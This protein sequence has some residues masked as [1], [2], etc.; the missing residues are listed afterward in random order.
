MNKDKPISEKVFLFA[1]ARLTYLNLFIISVLSGATY[2]YQYEIASKNQVSFFMASEF[3]KT[4]AIVLI[5]FIT[6]YKYNSSKMF[7][8][9]MLNYAASLWIF[10]RICD[11]TLQFSPSIRESLNTDVNV[12][13]FPVYIV[14]FI[15]FAA[16]GLYNYQTLEKLKVLA[17]CF[18]LTACLAFITSVAIV[19]SNNRHAQSPAFIIA[20]LLDVLI[21]AIAFSLAFYSS[22]DK[23]IMPFTF[24]FCVI[25]IADIFYLNTTSRFDAIDNP[26]VHFLTIIF[27][28]GI[29]TIGQQK[30]TR[31]AEIKKVRGENIML[32]CIET[33]ALSCIVG[34]L[35]YFFIEQKIPLELFLP[36]NAIF[37]ILLASEFLSY[38]HNK[39]LMRSREKSMR[40]VIKSSERF[41]VVFENS[42]T[43]LILL[44]LSGDIVHTNKTFSEFCG[45]E[46]DQVLGYSIGYVIHPDDRSLF[47]I[48]LAKVLGSDTTSSISIEC[49]FLRVDG[50]VRWG[51]TS[52]NHIPSSS[53]SD[54]VNADFVI[55]IE[56][57]TN[58]KIHETELVTMANRD[59][60][61][62]LWNRS[63]LSNLITKVLENSESENDEVGNESEK[64]P[65]VNQTFAVFFLDLDRFKII[66]DT[67]GHAAGD[68]V[69]QTTA[70]RLTHIVGTRGEVARLGGDEFVILFYPPTT[71]AI[72]ELV[73]EE[74]KVSVAQP[75]L[76]SQG[77]TII[78]CSIG[79]LM[80]FGNA[81]SPGDIMREAD[82]AM[83]RAKDNGKNFV[84]IAT[85]KDKNRNYSELKFTNDLRRALTT[86]QIKVYYQ[87]IVSLSTNEIIG[88]EALSRWEHPKKGLIS[89]DEFIPLAE[90]TGL[91]LEIGYYMMEHAFKQLS[92]WQKTYVPSSGKPLSMNVN[93][94]VSQ[95]RDPKLFRQIEEVKRQS[96]CAVNSMIF[97]ITESAVMGDAK[98]AIAL[99]HEIRDLGFRLRIDDFGTGYSS[100]SY[101]KK[102]PIDG[103]KIDKSFVD[104]LD[105]DENDTA[106]VHALLGLAHAMNL[107][108]TAEGIEFDRQRMS[109]K[110]LNCD[111]G[112]GYLFSEAVP[113][114][115]VQLK[116][117]VDNPMDFIRP[118]DSDEYTA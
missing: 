6:R 70:E 15:G 89:P 21:L 2:F 19:I 51:A 84:E 101:L 33:L 107:T 13:Y 9:K 24:S 99:L 27:Y 65:A 47:D 58:K 115:K 71:Q 25:A 8:W 7:G 43:A 20:A 87:P 1:N 78:T 81:L 91:I 3:I 76:L 23:V 62:G 45:L 46:Q 48:N 66:N 75:I 77:E 14:A 44:D 52:I 34:A 100:L 28:L 92:V 54:E 53:F 83:Y 30:E 29:V 68:I 98:H 113:A 39:A 22:F 117:N 26:F 4:A 108:V 36:L 79:A 67:L 114:H 74:I 80:C 106:I 86:D 112:Q 18:T 49:R 116:N 31:P 97:E 72:I 40:A 82:A 69:L 93:L 96:N 37:I 118:E 17:H 61:T 59:P 11:Q 50:E 109:L 35:T 73:A 55:Q 95:L 32:T 10:A 88:F 57:I 85:T 63:Y 41:R 102:M 16:I 104:G 12:F 42:P 105:I 94:S 90:D 103:F 60:L 111:Y 5:T 110:E 64:K 56:D 38:L